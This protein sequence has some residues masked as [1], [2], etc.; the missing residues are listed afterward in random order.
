MN[1]KIIDFFQWSDSFD[2]LVIKQ[3]SHIKSNWELMW[4]HDEKKYEP[5]ENSFAKMIN[6]LVV[7][8]SKLS[9]PNNYHDNEDRLVEFC[10]DN[11]DWNIEK[12]GNRWIC[13]DY[14]SILEQGAFDDIDELNL[15]LA[16]NGRVKAA[17]DRGQMH[18]DDMEKSHRK[19]L[20]D[21]LAIILYHR[22]NRT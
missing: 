12:K 8:L 10:K 22:N 15:L 17:L 18:F 11:L 4:N 6:D 19:M 1:E 9:P 21:V 2:Y 13:V 7:E 5:E 20:A 3:L 16:A 14:T